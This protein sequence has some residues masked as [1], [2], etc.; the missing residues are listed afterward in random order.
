MN[1]T[2]KK[3][4]AAFW[5]IVALGVM[6]GYPLSF[7]PACW[8]SERA[9]DDGKVVSFLYRPIVWASLRTGKAG[10]LALEYMQWGLRGNVR[11][12]ISSHGTVS[13]EG[14]TYGRRNEK[15][16]PLIERPVPIDFGA[17]GR[18]GRP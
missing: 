14:Y 16:N 2:R 7:G 9:E 15:P 13:W 11:V 5:T 4:G 6:L 12:F 18:M 1:D 17:G 8:I 3:H 10:H